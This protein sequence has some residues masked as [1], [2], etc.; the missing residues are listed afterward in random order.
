MNRANRSGFH[1][2][3]FVNQF[4]DIHQMFNSKLLRLFGCCNEQ[5][6]LTGAFTRFVAT[7]LCALAFMPAT[8]DASDQIPGAKQ[9]KPILIRGA[10][11]HTV[12]GPTI[13]GGSILLKDG[14]IA[15]ISANIPVS[16]GYQVIEATGKHVYP[17]LIDSFSSL[18]LIEVDSVR[19][20]IDNAETGNI[21]SNVK[22]AV[23]FNPDSEAIPVGRANG[24]LT[25]VVTPAGGLIAGRASVMMSDGWTWE[26]MTLKADVA[27]AVNWPRFGSGGGGPGGGGRGRF[28]GQEGGEG[29]EGDNDRLSAL[30]ELFRE[31][32]A[33]AAAKKADPSGTT[34]D[35]RLDAMIPVVEG[36]LPMLVNANL[37]KQIQTAVAFGQQ[38]GIKMIIVGGADAIH[39]SQLL[40]DTQTPVIIP[41]TYRL[42]TRRDA[43]YDASYALP[44]QLKAAGIKVA[45]ASDGR[46]GASMIRNL[47][48]HAATA[49]GF[50]LSEDDAV[51]CITL[52]PAEIFGVADRVGSLEVGKDATLIVTDGNVLEIASNVQSAFIQGRAVDLSSKHTRLNDKYKTKYE[53][54]K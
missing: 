51:R 14:K 48:Y 12:S 6:G 38:Y 1:P 26:D 19:A 24:I 30:H 45:I 17:G 9:A 23:A 7:A 27:M 18:G 20:T 33:Y 31:T 37:L 54:M 42:P 25:S 40:V 16:D 39:C 52:T 13:E 2:V 53:R 28:R 5:M 29:E 34:V 50:G 35:L 8:V 49:V 15:E 41:S 44:A 46:F 47:P 4:S 21:N 43:G 11:I 3:P 36:K 10:T 32:K 22:A